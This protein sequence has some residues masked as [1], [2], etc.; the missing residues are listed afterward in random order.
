MTDI[1]TIENINNLKKAMGL[2]GWVVFFGLTIYVH[3]RLK[4]VKKIERKI[5]S[6][7]EEIDD[8]S[9]KMLQK[10]RNSLVNQGQL[11]KMIAKE[12]KPLEK[13]TRNL[14]QKRQF[15]LDKLPFFGMFKK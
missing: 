6:K 14:K 3:L 9:S 2:I 7:Q 12:Q 5:D 1:C 11:D 15:I 8:L 10:T 4:E 13:E